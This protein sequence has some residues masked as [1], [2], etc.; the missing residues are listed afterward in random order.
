MPGSQTKMGLRSAQQ[1]LNFV[2]ERAIPKNYTL[3]CSSILTH[4]NTC[5]FSI[6]TTLCESTNIFLSRTIKN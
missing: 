3:D 5:S 6:K 2:M 1:K 4:S